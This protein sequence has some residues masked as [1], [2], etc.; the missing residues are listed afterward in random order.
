MT[1]KQ[2]GKYT[3]LGEL[4]AGG[5]GAV[6]RAEDPQLQRHVAIK[7]LPEEF[8]SDPERLARLRREAQLLASLS[9]P[10][11]AAVHGFEEDAG[12]AF[13]VMELVE[14]QGLDDLLADGPLPLEE[15]LPLALQIA[16]GLEAA[17]EAGIVH[18]DLKPANIRITPD[19]QAKVL[20]FGLAKDLGA[21]GG[22]ASF[23]ISMSPTVAAATMAGVILGT[24]A[25]MSPEQARGAALD[26]RTDIWS[27]GCVFFQMLTGQL[28][29]GGGTVTDMMASV[30]KDEP[31]WDQ[32]P[33]RLPARL[34]RLLRRCLQKKPRSRLRDIGDARQEIEDVLSGAPDELERDV[35]ARSPLRT[36]GAI[37]AVAA[38]TALATFLATS[39]FIGPAG[40][41]RE[42]LYFE[43][44]LLS[45]QTVVVGSTRPTISADGSMIA[46]A[47]DTPEGRRILVRHLDRPEPY[48]VEGT[49]G[50]RGPFFSPD[51]EW[52]GFST[53]IGMYRVP[54]A[55][56]TP[57]LIRS[58]G[59]WQARGVWPSAER[60]LAENNNVG[61]A[62]IV[63]IDVSN[64][65]VTELTVANRDAGEVQHHWPY[66][67]PDGTVLFSIRYAADA[68]PKLG[69][70]DPDAG[71]YRTLEIQAAGPFFYLDGTLVFSRSGRLYRARFSPGA[72]QLQSSPEAFLQ[73]A[74]VNHAAFSR[75]GRLVY[76]HIPEGGR[77]IVRVGRDGAI[78]SLVETRENYRW[79]R[80]SPDGSRIVT[81]IETPELDGASNIWVIDLESQRRWMLQA[82]GGATEPV[83][84]PDG[85]SIVHSQRGAAA[86]NLARQPADGSGSPQALASADFDLWPSDFSPDGSQFLYYG[87]DVGGGQDSNSGDPYAVWAVGTDGS[88]PRVII[89]RPGGQRGP[90]FSPDGRFIAYVSNES[91]RY[92]VYVEPYPELDRRWTVSTDG[93][94]DAVWARDGSAIFYRRGTRLYSVAVTLQ[95]DFKVGQ[96]TVV[97]DAPFWFDPFY[98]QSYDVFPDG[99]SFALFRVAPDE[100]PRVRVFTGLP[101]LMG[102][103]E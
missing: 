83:W 36:A 35:A 87:G 62:G 67:M 73:D 11:L 70:Y 38:G 76:F 84:A 24:A 18:R 86:F 46:F 99:Q 37:A 60:I 95:P 96:E 43:E 54:L 103:A 69:I 78:R 97:I 77:E 9:H 44:N 52:L 68:A 7:V 79:L 56:G 90:R 15:A 92:E 30:V 25:Y 57:T 80:L 19:H 47:V 22:D 64:G 61:N 72:D 13:L 29:F 2:L 6:Y 40:S 81:G 75:D 17:H 91:G 4:G 26:K 8:A 34:G 63:E 101:E 98:D 21:E 50:G 65:T 16:T 33:A 93:G 66:P 31:N 45:G 94:L 10:N 51:G 58:A 1:P 32:L 12:K 39:S 20:D 55:G 74:D 59:F 28:P 48:V 89:D 14:G 41:P 23:K 100:A 85:R 71:T 102:G 82:E 5:M 27:F 42:S 49:D 3:V 53:E 88:D